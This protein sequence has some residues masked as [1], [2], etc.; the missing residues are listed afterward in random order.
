MGRACETRDRPAQEKTEEGSQAELLRAREASTG[1]ASP[2]SSDMQP[3][4]LSFASFTRMKARAPAVPSCT[5]L[6]R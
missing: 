2:H 3:S 5:Q 4:Q 6:S 1:V